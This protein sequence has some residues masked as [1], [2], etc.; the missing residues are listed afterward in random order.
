MIDPS[1]GIRTRSCNLE[2]KCFQDAEHDEF[3]TLAM[4][5]ELNQFERNEVWNLVPR[6]ED[7]P[8]IG[9]K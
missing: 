2:P 9:T 6:P 4:Q 3:W 5:E 1:Q 7:H 8:V